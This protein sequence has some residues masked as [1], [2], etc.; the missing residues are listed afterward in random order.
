MRHIMARRRSIRSVLHNFLGGFTSRYSDFD[1]YWI[2]GM[3]VVDLDHTAIDLLGDPRDVVGGEPLQAAIRRARILFRE[4]LA[5]GQLDASVVREARLEMK[6]SSEPTP[7]MINGHVATRYEITFTARAVSDLD[8][9]YER[10]RSVFV[11]PHDPSIEY[12]RAGGR[13]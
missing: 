10:T 11:A 13:A 3:L 6:R 9:V 7:G 4:Q 1:G 5:R 8:A 12:R 2:F